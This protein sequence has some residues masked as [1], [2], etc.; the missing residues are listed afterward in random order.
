[1]PLVTYL[2]T[3]D[4]QS[5]L[6]SSA[7][8]ACSFWNR[9]VEP[10]SSIVIRLGVFTQ[11]GS[12]IARAYYPYKRDGVVYGVVEFNTRFLK[13]YTQVEIVG[14]LIHEIGHTLGI[15]W[16]KWMTMFSHRTGR[17]HKK[18]VN[19]L[20]ALKDMYVETD[21]GPGTTLSHWDE[22]KFGKELMTGIKNDDEHVLPVTI[23]VVELLGHKVIEKLE[24]KKDL[25]EILSELRN[26]MFTR[27]EEVTHIV[28]DVYIETEIWE[29]I[30]DKTRTSFK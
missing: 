10:E 25:A 30:Y 4:Y 24:K 2:I 8:L 22:D 20:P 17:F 26:I 7:K 12:T 6:R 3:S 11:F 19:M 28:R 16:D 14:T 9:F 13:R 27:Q 5:M 29:E 23:D 15:G 21:Y 18:W 1:M